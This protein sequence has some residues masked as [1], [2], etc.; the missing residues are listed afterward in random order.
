MAVVSALPWL[1]TACHRH[2]GTSAALL[3]DCGYINLLGGL[4]AVCAAWLC[5]DL[6]NFRG[7]GLCLLRAARGCCGLC[8]SWQAERCKL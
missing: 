5:F 2:M 7:R 1:R 4:R 6:E 3:P 8:C